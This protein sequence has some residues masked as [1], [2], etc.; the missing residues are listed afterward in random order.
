VAF[1]DVTND[2]L[3]VAGNG[4]EPMTIEFM[5]GRL[6]VG[7][8]GGVFVADAT[9]VNPTWTRLGAGL[10]NAIVTDLTFDRD[11]KTLFA[12]TFGRGIWS[13]PAPVAPPPK[14][15]ECYE[16]HDAPL[17]I[18]GVTLIDQFGRSTVTIKKAKRLCAPANETCEDPAAVTDPAHLT[19]YTIKQTMPRF[20]PVRDV[21]VSNRFGTLVVD[22][23]KPDRLLAPAAKSLTGVPGPLANPTDHYKCY[24]VAGAR[25]R[26]P[27]VP[28]ETQFGELVLD[29]KRP[30]HLCAPVDKNDEGLLDADTHLMCYLVRAGRPTVPPLVFTRDQFDSNEFPLFGVRE[31]CVPSKKTLP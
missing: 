12:G 18:E 27:D 22:L 2:L 9:A 8:L 28:V 14:H 7:G 17:N 30:L 21:T 1:T 11:S 24:R 3:T 31:L 29:I 16:T 10:P 25:F 5:N 19:A 26:K 20:E 6:A 15:F 13:I 23:V 4:F